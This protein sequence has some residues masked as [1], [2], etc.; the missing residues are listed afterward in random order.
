M[1]LEQT[2]DYQ[3]AN[4]E[5][6]AVRGPSHPLGISFN[7][8]LVRVKWG[9]NHFIVRSIDADPPFGDSIKPDELT[10]ILH[11]NGVWI[12][13]NPP[14]PAQY[15]HAAIAMGG[16]FHK[17]LSLVGHNDDLGWV[18]HEQSG[19]RYAYV[20]LDTSNRWREETWDYVFSWCK[21][22]MEI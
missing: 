5:V 10:G 16:R 1:E 12:P 13:V 18:T 22:A 20:P 19:V 14:L 4:L 17:V 7:N 2:A 11:P 6:I 9:Y 8:P 15:D 3:W 21:R